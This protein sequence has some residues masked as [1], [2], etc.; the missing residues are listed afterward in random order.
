MR[1]EPFTRFEIFDADE[2][3]MTGTAA[4]VVP[5]VNVDARP[6][7]QGRPGALTQ[8]LS[9]RF[10]K[11][12]SHDGTRLDGRYARPVGLAQRWARARK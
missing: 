9:K 11:L 3:F 2:C 8:V 1:E 10:R 5:V 6:I 4:E 12:V 7:G